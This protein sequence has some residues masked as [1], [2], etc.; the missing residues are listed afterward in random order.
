[1]K[2]IYSVLVVAA[3]SMISCK[4]S[5][6]S[7]ESSEAT[8]A[9][10]NDSTAAATPG[11]KALFDGKSLAGW[12]FFKGKENNSWEVA[13]GTL[14]CKP[15]D[16]HEKRADLITTDQYGNYELSFDWKVAAKSNS[17]VMYKVTEEFD[18]PYLSGPEYQVLDDI[19]WPGKIE[20]WQKT[21]SCY[22][23]Y[24]ATAAPKPVGEWNNSK[25]VVNGN[26]VE[27]WLNG[28]KVVE[29]E[30]N[31]DDW[32]KRKDEY[33]WKDAKGY[34]QSAKGYIAL[35]DHGGEVWFKNIVIKEI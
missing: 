32:K 6:E 16:G 3:V 5:T 29:Y 28:V 23:M 33:K 15:F 18:E 30:I 2:F 25:I 7:K 9:T 34:A 21:A 19:G 8:A 35:Q 31:S 1:M 27:H 4:P 26:H 13:E 10:S 17:G 14:H 22:A 11:V 20:P 24:V 12:K